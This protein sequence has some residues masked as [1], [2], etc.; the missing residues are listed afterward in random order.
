MVALL[1]LLDGELA[2][3]ASYE[4]DSGAVTAEVALA[5]ADAVTPVMLTQLLRASRTGMMEP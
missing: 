3:L 4:L 5:F 1:G 2:G